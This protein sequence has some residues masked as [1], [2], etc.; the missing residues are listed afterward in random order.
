MD[1]PTLEVKVP[2]RIYILF[3]FVSL[4]PAFAGPSA[5]D[6]GV[7]VDQDLK[8]TEVTVT[9]PEGRL[10]ISLDPLMNLV[11]HTM[12]VYDLLG[13]HGRDYTLRGDPAVKRAMDDGI[14][15][16]IAG[17]EQYFNVNPQ[18]VNLYAPT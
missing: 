1:L 18:R 5:S 2:I 8:R 12:N 9:T 4:S 17:R 7:A 11:I 6:A 14:Y 13:F 10:I 15:G 3:V 16:A